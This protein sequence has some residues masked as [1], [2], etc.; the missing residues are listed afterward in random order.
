MALQS[1]CILLFVG[2]VIFPVALR[3]RVAATAWPW[4]VAASAAL[5]VG[6]VLGVRAWRRGANAM[7]MAPMVASLAFGVVIVYGFIAPTADPRRGHREL[8]DTLARLIPPGV[9]SIH[10]YNELDEGLWFY[11][12]GVGLTP[13]PGTQ[14]RYSTSY[15]L[16]AAYRARRSPSES[17]EQLDIRR[18][19]MEKQALLSWL[20]DAPPSFLLIRSELFDRYARDLSSA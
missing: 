19:A 11:L 13:V 15:D 9:G 7:A 2:T 14:P 8:A 17:I 3:P 5:A 10:F 6:V 18:E 1:Q 4:A 20:D 16:V 12:H